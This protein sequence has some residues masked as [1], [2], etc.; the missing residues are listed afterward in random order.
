MKNETLKLILKLLKTSHCILENQ[1]EDENEICFEIR[2]KRFEF[3]LYINKHNNTSRIYQTCDKELN[4]ELSI[5]IISLKKNL[6]EIFAKEQSN[7]S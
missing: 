4:N 1:E 7:K 5:L 3:D 6:A 2:I